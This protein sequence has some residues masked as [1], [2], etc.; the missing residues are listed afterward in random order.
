MKNGHFPF[1][2]LALIL[3]AVALWIGGIAEIKFNRFPFDWL[4]STTLA[5]MGQL[6]SA[7]NVVGVLVSALAFAGLIY[8]VALQRI[9]LRTALQEAKAA[10]T[11]RFREKIEE[12]WFML[13]HRLQGIQMIQTEKLYLHGVALR[14]QFQMKDAKQEDPTTLLDL[15]F[16]R[17][18][19]LNSGAIDVF[20]PG[21]VE[22]FG[23]LGELRMRSD[24]KEQPLLDNSLAA[25]VT[26]KQVEQGIVQAIA[27]GNTNALRVIRDSGLLSIFVGNEERPIVDQTIILILNA[28][29]SGE[30]T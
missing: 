12:R 24:E 7:L 17:T 29:K 10:E 4:G 8:T 19:I 27:R 25:F 28:A 3:L 23:A 14:L 13:L 22:T 18:S 5:Q 20:S 21:L 2:G 11:I 6:G 30:S 16:F 15:D 26:E 1:G 9:Q